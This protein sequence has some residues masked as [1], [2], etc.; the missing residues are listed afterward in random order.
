MTNSIALEMKEPELPQN[1]EER[2]NA[3]NSYQILDTL[4]EKDYDSITQ[5]AS[6]ICDTPISLIS[7]IDD[8]RQWF[9]S[10]HGLQATETPKE[11]AF[12][13]HA[14]VH[15]GMVLSVEDSRLDERF[16]DNPLV[17]GDPHVIFYS[18][19]PLVNPD[20]HALGTLCVIDHKPKL[21]SQAQI[22]SLKALAQQVVN[23]LELRKANAALQ[24][25]NDRLQEF[26]DAVEGELSSPLNQMSALTGLLESVYGDKLDLKGQEV[27]KNLNRT[28]HELSNLIKQFLQNRQ[29]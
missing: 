18:G 15:P 21:L 24:E 26:A 2:V 22:K 13:A 1:E 12:C 17:N 29:H 8:K 6:A 10:R 3:L 28:S 14:I 11:Y 25:H 23:L 9:K 4:P 7:L 5:L 27:L 20:G 19:I 16:K